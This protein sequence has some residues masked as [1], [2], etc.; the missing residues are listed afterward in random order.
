M[1][2]Y[3]FRESRRERESFHFNRAYQLMCDGSS[4]KKVCRYIMLHDEAPDR[5]ANLS[6]KENPLSTCCPENCAFAK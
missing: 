5:D 3:I 1:C 6:E 4:K 2:V